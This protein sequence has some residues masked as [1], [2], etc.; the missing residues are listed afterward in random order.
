MG[1][2]P[3]K[4]LVEWEA[5]LIYQKT[6]DMFQLPLKIFSDLKSSMYHSLH[7][8]IFQPSVGPA[9]STHWLR[10]K[11]RSECKCEWLLTRHI[12]LGKWRPAGQRRTTWADMRLKTSTEETFKKKLPS[13]F[14]TLIARICNICQN[15]A[16]KKIV[17]WSQI[18]KNWQRRTTWADMRLKTSTEETFKKKLLEPSSS[19]R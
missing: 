16:K 15:S 5:K 2:S 11:K 8:Q 19:D 17:F 7:L 6:W 12:T 10:N 13:S 3:F 14:E 18:F 9:E 4:I 1:Q